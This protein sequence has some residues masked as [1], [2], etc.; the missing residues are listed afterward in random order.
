L[1]N[2]QSSADEIQS[3][4]ELEWKPCPDILNEYY[5]PPL[6]FHISSTRDV[7]AKVCPG[8][9][10]GGTADDLARSLHAEPQRLYKQA[11]DAYRADARRVYAHICINSG[12]RGVAEQADLYRAWRRSVHGGPHAPNANLPGTSKH[13][14]GFAIDVIRGT[15]ES[16]LVSALTGNGWVQ[17]SGDEGWHFEAKDASNWADLISYIANHRPGAPSELGGKIEDG[18]LAEVELRA[19][20]DFIARTGP[21]LQAEKVRLDAWRDR[22]VQW[23]QRL[24]TWQQGL[25]HAQRQVE[26]ARLASQQAEADYRRFQ[27]SSCPNGQPYE[28]CTHADLKSRFDQEKLQKERIW[29]EAYRE[30]TQLRSGYE[31]ERSSYQAEQLSYN[32]DKQQYAEGLQRYQQARAELNQFVQ[33]EA[34][35]TQQITRIR[36]EE[37]NL[38]SNVQAVVDGF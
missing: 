11:N 21:A 31:A 26:Q 18:V 3:A 15:D 7:L 16:R 10:E 32:G 9:N 23:Q 20:R 12:R 17:H 38:I 30:Y 35:L 13:E 14:Y 29:R 4:A 19:V 6:E 27:Y 34:A 2:E 1:S 22:L 28:Q 24:Q 25:S 8:R 37:L 36:N 5:A 33:K